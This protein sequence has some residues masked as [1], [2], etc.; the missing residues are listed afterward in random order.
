MFGMKVCNNFPVKFE[1]KK[2]LHRKVI[3]R[4]ESKELILLIDWEI[5]F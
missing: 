1:G 2:Y 5:V 3:L 4:K